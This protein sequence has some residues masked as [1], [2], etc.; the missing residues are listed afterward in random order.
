METNWHKD[1]KFQNYSI[2]SRAFPPHPET[3]DAELRTFDEGKISMI[4]NQNVK[5]LIQEK[6]DDLDSNSV[7]SKAV[8]KMIFS[9]YNS[10]KDIQKNLL[11]AVQ[12]R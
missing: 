11:H 1:F 6:K 8:M 2:P 4:K 9:G 10:S 5:K 7:S 12:N 3:R